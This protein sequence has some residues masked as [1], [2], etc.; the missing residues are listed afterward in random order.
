MTMQGGNDRVL[1][2]DGD[3]VLDERDICSVDQIQESLEAFLMGDITL[4]QLEGV[5]ADEMYA[6][7]D[8]GYD[9]YEEGKLGEA[10]TIF[11]GLSA[12]N[13]WDPYFHS[14]LGSI[15]QHQGDCRRAIDRYKKAVE[16][17]PE[18]VSSW[19]NLGEAMLSLLAEAPE[20]EPSRQAELF[21]AAV[22]ALSK[23]IELDPE[24]NTGSSVRARA[25]VAST[26]DACERLRK[27]GDPGRS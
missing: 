3:V 16:L 26:A 20:A 11:E 9:L 14:V 22:Q 1:D 5:T 4:A 12:Y 17:F 24:S 8:I 25:I 15:L 18:D 6:I 23:A 7:A 19:T 2:R 27:Q 13:P 21:E 10:R